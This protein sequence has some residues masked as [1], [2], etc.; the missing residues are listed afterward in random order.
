MFRL[1]Y[2]GNSVAFYI[3]DERKCRLWTIGF[4][5]AQDAAPLLGYFQFGEPGHDPQGFGRFLAPI[6]R[7]KNGTTRRPSLPKTN[8]FLVARVAE[9]QRVAPSFTRLLKA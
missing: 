8:E 7:T 6:T 2:P 9:T 5:A 3:C 4:S 1:A